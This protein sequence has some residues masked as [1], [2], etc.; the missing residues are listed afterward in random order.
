MAASI[1]F[2]D[3]DGST[4]I[5]TEDLGSILSPGSSS[6]KLLYVENNGDQTATDVEVSIEQIGTND[7]DDYALLA[8]DVALSPGA[9][10]TSPVSLGDIAAGDKEPF[11]AKVTLVAGLSAQGNTRQFKLHAAG[12]T[13]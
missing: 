9:F 6:N 8:P 2:L 12:A 7:G 10:S 4:V 11:W 5:T 3:T 13:I 1:R